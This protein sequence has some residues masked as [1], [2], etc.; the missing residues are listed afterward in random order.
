MKTL[1]LAIF[2]KTATIIFSGYM[3]ALAVIEI[4]LH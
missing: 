3:L 1:N 4:I 2:V